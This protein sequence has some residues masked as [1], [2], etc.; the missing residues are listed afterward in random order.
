VVYDSLNQYNVEIWVERIPLRRAM[1]RLS[2][3]IETKAGEGAGT[4][5]DGERR[6]VG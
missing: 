4:I 6:E 2:A 3:T 1:E 5:R